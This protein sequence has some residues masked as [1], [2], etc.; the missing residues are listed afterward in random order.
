MAVQIE[1]GQRVMTMTT[2]VRRRREE[3]IGRIEMIA[4]I[5]IETVTGIEIATETETGTEETGTEEIETEIGT[6]ANTT[7]TMT[8][9]LPRV[10]DGM[11]QMLH[12]VP[13]LF[14]Q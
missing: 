8:T 11:H 5:R 2:V 12:M 9:T 13:I 3:T 14:Q 7:T 6:D 4:E 10:G 1:G